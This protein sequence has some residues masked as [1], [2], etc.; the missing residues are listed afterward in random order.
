MVTSQPLARS[1]LAAASAMAWLKDVFSAC[2]STISAL[3]PAGRG[4]SAPPQQGP[5]P[6]RDGPG[7]THDVLQAP[8]GA[9][10]TPQGAPPYQ[11]PWP[12]DACSCHSSPTAAA[13]HVAVGRSKQAVPC[14]AVLCH[15]TTEVEALRPRGRQPVARLINPCSQLM[16][17]ARLQRRENAWGWEHHSPGAARQLWVRLSHLLRPWGG[18][19]WC[20]CWC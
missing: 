14:H 4:S 20:W 18:S 1:V 3:R 7:G 2:A 5:Q 11:C 15:S 13:R 16:L 8:V 19:G 12:P 10:W 6:P 9:T 17:P